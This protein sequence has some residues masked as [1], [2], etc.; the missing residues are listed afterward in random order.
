[1]DVTTLAVATDLMITRWGSEV[2]D[3]GPYLLVRTPDEPDFWFGQAL[4][5]PPPAP[6][7]PGPAWLARWQASFERELPAATHRALVV[8]GDVSSAVEAAATAAGWAVQRNVASSARALAEAPPPAGVEVRPLASDR[9]WAQ[10]V[11]L[12]LASDEHD[13]APDRPVDELHRRFVRGRV[14]SKRA[15]VE[16]GRGAWWGALAGDALVGSLGVVGE[17]ELARY[18]DVVT[19]PAWRRRGVARALLTAAGRAA[20]DRGA[21]RLVI[22]AIAG[23]DPLRLYRAAGFAPADT[24]VELLRRPPA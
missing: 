11:A 23:G 12:A 14:A 2:T 24:S 8:D 5:V 15:W 1:M 18:Q 3:R 6:A 10:V 13:A 19:H 20:L 9:D 16:A 7:E 17:G 21:R 22:V 4:V